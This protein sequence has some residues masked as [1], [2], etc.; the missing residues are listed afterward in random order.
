MPYSIYVLLPPFATLLIFLILNVYHTQG[1]ILNY[2]RSTTTYTVLPPDNGK[3][4]LLNYGAF[5][6]NDSFNQSYQSYVNI[7]F[8]AIFSGLLVHYYASKLGWDNC[9]RYLKIH[10]P[11]V[12]Y[13]ISVNLNIENLA[14]RDK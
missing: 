1:Q 11:F 5:I 3:R 14:Y 12:G 7:G 4:S 2:Y 6:M 10:K 9:V 8:T 13:H